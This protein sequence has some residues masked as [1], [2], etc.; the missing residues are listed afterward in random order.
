MRRS[1]QNLAAL[2]EAGPEAVLG[3]ASKA[4]FTGGL[5]SSQASSRTS[6]ESMERAK[7]IIIVSNHLPI[8]AQRNKANAWEFDWDEDA[9]VAQAK[10]GIDDSKDV[11]YVGC[12][13]VEVEVSEQEAVRSKLRHLHC[14]PV[15]LGKDLKEKF[16]KGCCKQQLW[17]LLHY[18]LPMSPSSPGRFNQE[19][20]QAYKRA[21]MVFAQ[22]V[23]CEVTSKQ[24]Y[25]WIHDYHLL[26]LPCMLRMRM[27]SARVG[28]FLHSPFPSSEIFRTFPKRNEILRSML[29]AD[30]IGFHT[31]DYARH[32]LSCCSRMLGLDH[33]ASRG[34]IGVEYYGRN[35]GIKIMPTGVNPERLLSG[36]EWADTK[37]RRG[38]L[39]SELEGLTVMIGVDDLDSF[40]GIELKLQAFQRILEYHPEWRG[41]LC[42]V[43]ITNAPRASGP[44]LQELVQYI[45]N[46][47]ATI[48]DR[49]GQQ[50]YKPVK[51]L[52]RHVPL[53]ERIAFYSVADV[54][55]L[56]ATRDGMN[57]APYEYVVCRQG[58]P[59]AEGEDPDSTKTSMLVV[60]EFV[61]CSPSLCGAIR[62]NPWSVSSLADGMRNALGTSE[63]D[64]RWRHDK[65]W[66][67]VSKNTVSF[68]AQS[69]V[70]ELEKITQMNSTMICY[71]M[72]LGLD[73]FKMVSLDRNFR[74][75]ETMAL[76]NVYRRSN[77]RVFFLDYDGTLVPSS[78]LNP[79]PSKKVL[80]VLQA[81][82]SDPKNMVYIIS[83]RS[84][85]ELGKWF[86][87]VENL[88][89][90]A[91]HGFFYRRADSKEWEAKAS[92]EDCENWKS[93]V[94]PIFQTY[95]DATDGSYMEIKESA[96]VWHFRDA[97]PDFGNLQAKELLTHLEEILSNEP[98]EV[99][100]GHYIVEAK[101]A[102]MSKGQVVER[103]LQEACEEE[104]SGPDLILCIGDDRSDEVMF[105]LIEHVTFSPHMPAEVFACTVGQKP[106]KAK[107][108]VDDP[109]NVLSMLE[110]LVM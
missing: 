20:W 68:W 63:E 59:V 94:E 46:L 64:Q 23:I 109:D 92:L 98:V 90:S 84:R 78:S 86:S 58:A 12:L 66:K 108:Y 1:C 30:L 97:D 81:L 87:E 62:V 13:N 54:L 103:V 27:D 14:S 95:M 75:L 34:S 82:C 38:E 47:V 99:V 25:I 50:G 33:S 55:V 85:K 91:E 74:K 16:Y 32:F 35:V 5:P 29:N 71:K 19:M 52:E 56:S 100:S 101:P 88:G 83:G 39:L 36:F 72:G 15:F 96:I 8:R 93:L 102:K 18:V 89:L 60:S 4:W 48:N 73:T 110:K 104:A 79:A 51:Y 21:N 43:Q 10:D 37:W 26:V 22:A 53:H 69:Y 107:F 2:L 80:T 45:R 11:H 6:V 76:L 31:F 105:D 65:H 70:A 40:K 28:L 49:F 7:R 42:L 3:D 24:N 106:S 41:K 44:D 9:L 61:G 77:K 67:Y 17:P 57:L